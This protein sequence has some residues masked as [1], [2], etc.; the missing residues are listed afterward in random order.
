[1]QF[2]PPPLDRAALHSLRHKLEH[3][4]R[5]LELVVA[6]IDQAVGAIESTDADFKQ[7]R[8]KSMELIPGETA[9]AIAEIAQS[10]IERTF[11]RSLVL[12]FLQDDGLGLL[13]HPT[14]K[15]TPAEVAD[16]RWAL[17]DFQSI[18]PLFRDYKPK[19]GL[20]RLL[21][22]ELTSGRMQLE[23]WRYFASL[24][25]KYHC[26]P[27]DGSYHMTLQPCF[28]DIKIAGTPVRAD[29]YFWIP[30]HPDINIIVECDGFEF[31]STKEKF[32]S[33]RQRDRAF[34]ARG[35]DVMRFSG[36]E[37]WTDPLSVS[38]ELATYLWERAN[39]ATAADF[40]TAVD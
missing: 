26:A 24:I 5:F 20:S 30:K 25:S 31:H 29:L 6:Y 36:S 38:N 22:N 16:F 9:R 21:D 10:P 23:E 8:R 12:S 33:D 11:I 39:R 14:F 15:G 35:Y 40:V 1:M 4:R 19:D 7:F 2:Q 28:P 37:I 3:D 13:V 18:K 32:K 17:S 27:L 34:K